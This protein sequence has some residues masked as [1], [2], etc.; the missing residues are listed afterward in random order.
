MH[1]VKHRLLLNYKVLRIPKRASAWNMPTSMLETSTEMVNN[2]ITTINSWNIL[3]NLFLILFTDLTRL[4]VWVLD[5]DP[6]HTNLLKYAINETNFQHTLVIL[7]V[8]MSTPWSWQDQLHH[9]IKVLA[10]H[11]DKLNIS[12]GNYASFH[13]INFM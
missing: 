5:G 3:C 10:N 13:F 9:W 6:G 2:T 7:T 1:R 8:S 12:P 11:V 4:G